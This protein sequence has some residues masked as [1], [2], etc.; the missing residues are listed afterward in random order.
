MIFNPIHSLG[1]PSLSVFAAGLFAAGTPA[2]PPMR[3]V[4]PRDNGAELTNPGM[5]WALHYYDNLP[6]HYGSRLAPSDLLPNWPGLAFLYLRIPWSYIE[7]KE[8]Q[9][10][11]AVLDTPIERFRPRGLQAAFRITCSESWC[12]YATP[13]WVRDAGAKGY[14][15]RPGAGIV[16]NGPFWEPDFDDPVFLAKL[17]HFLAAF[18]A[19][20]DGRTDVA[21]VEVGSFGVWGE[22]HTW[23]STRKAYPDSTIEKHI[24]LYLKHFKKTRILG[25]DDFASRPRPP[26]PWKAGINQRGFDAVIIPAWRGRT[27]RLRA[28][29]WRPNSPDHAGRLRPKNDAGDRTVELGALTITDQG[30]IR[31]AP[32]GPGLPK[33]RAGL[34]GA[35]FAVVCTGLRRRPA[36]VPHSFKVELAYFLPHPLDPGVHPF[37]HFLDGGGHEVFVPRLEQEDPALTRFMAGHGLGLRDDSILVQG[38]GA[39]YFHAFMAQSFWRQAPVAVESEHYGPSKA[40]GCWGDG[41]GFFEAIEDYHA[42]YASIHWWPHEFLAENR[43]LVRRINLRIGYRFQLCEFSWPA[44]LSLDQTF[45]VSWAWR[46]AGVAPPYTDYFPAVTLADAKGG[47]VAVFVDDNAN[48]RRLPVAL[49][50]VE[51]RSFQRRFALPPGLKPGDYTVLVSVG[52][53]IGQPQAALPLDGGNGRRRYRLGTCRIQGDYTVSLVAVK[54]RDHALRLTLDWQVHRFLGRPVQVFLH[55]DRGGRLAWAG[56]PKTER[57]PAGKITRITADVPLPAFAPGQQCE[58]YAGLW[59]PTRIGRRDERCIPDAGTGDRRVLLGR[60]RA[61]AGGKLRFFPANR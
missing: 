30:E 40:R 58:I 38:G 22:G 7:P 50:G 56:G 23:A 21:F 53:R 4:H 24:Q 25:M 60:I 34:R 43:D 49:R 29:L 3:T 16:E 19:R 31:F 33:T 2:G 6:S 57:F 44:R 17:D 9:F 18:A 48:L 32:A 41:T 27:F 52:D 45:P 54:L 15:F 14:R 13:K 42:S 26:A 10:N 20:Y 8:N 47:I 36:A 55:L 12:E 1:L 35:D 51:P 61:D 28:G 5:G 11:W 39:A 59:R 37:L 46:N